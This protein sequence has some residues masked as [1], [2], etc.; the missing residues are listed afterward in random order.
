[1]PVRNHTKKRPRKFPWTFFAATRTFGGV[2]FFFLLSVVVVLSVPRHAQAARLW[3]S[4]FEMGTSTQG[5][6]GEFGSPAKATSTVV[7]SGSYAARLNGFSSFTSIGITVS[8]TNLNGPYFVR[9]YLY[10]TTLP[11]ASNTIMALRSS[12]G[13]RIVFIK[14]DSTGKLILADEDGQIGSSTALS[15][16]SW[17]RVEVQYDRTGAGGF[18]V[19]RA[20]LDG[21]EFAGA[22]NRN[23]S[24]GINRFSLGANISTE[25]Q[26]VGDW[27][28]DDVAMNDNAGS[29]QN[30]FPGEGKIVHLRPN[31]AGDNA[32]GTRGGANTGSDWGQLSEVTP[33]SA[34]TYYILDV[35][36][37]IIDVNIDAA[38]VAGMS[39]TDIISLVQVGIRERAATAAAEGWKVRIKSQGGGTV[40]SSATTTHD[41]IT[42]KTNGDIVSHIYPLTAYVD[43]QAGGAWTTALLDNSQ[44]GVLAGDATPD[45]WVSTLWALVEYTTPPRLEQIHYR[46]RNDD[47][48]EGAGGG[49]WHDFSW[50]YRQKITVQSSK[51]SSP[52]SNFPVYLDLAD[53]GNDFWAHVGSTCGDIRMT[54]A[55]GI[56]EIP[57]ELVSCSSTAKTG[58]VHFKAPSLASA[59]NTDFYAYF[60]NSGASDYAS[61][62]TYGANNVWDS[63]YKGVWHFEESLIDEGSTTDVHA[64]STSNPNDGDQVGE[65]DGVGKIGRGIKFDGTNDTVNANSDASL[66]N[67]AVKTASFWVKR[68]D[69]TRSQ[70]IV[71]KGAYNASGNGWIAEIR[72]NSGS[73]ADTI[74]YAH[75]WSGSAGGGATWYG[76][77]ALS[78][79]NAWYYATIVY[80]SGSASNNPLIYVN[81]SA[82][83][84]GEL[85]APSGT[86]GDDNASNLEFGINQSTYSNSEVDEVRI[87][88]IA[89]SASW[90]MTDYNNQSSPST[91][92]TTSTVEASSSGTT[93]AAAEDQPIFDVPKQTTRRL[94]FEISNEGVGVSVATQYRIEYATSSGASTWTQIGTGAASTN[95]WVMTPSQLVEGANTTDVAGGLN[96]ENTTFVAGRQLETSN[97]S[98]AITL[99]STEFTELEYSIAATSTA[100][101]GQTYYFRL[102]N[103]GA[104]LDAYTIYASATLAAAASPNLTQIHYRWS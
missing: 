64:D 82:E 71:Q 18:H 8:S 78:D 10:V 3:S 104:P 91:F 37:D 14:L 97:Q 72:S 38:S 70:G 6:E 17:Y 62:A 39:A 16:N 74:L 81:G 84:V 49:S 73:G 52:Q 86:E 43:P 7:H 61:S 68:V 2:F 1:M 44:I 28:F 34:G 57:R 59:T 50:N 47:G 55:D 92:Y 31:G 95:H 33:D 79:L 46:W 21:V 22:V 94:R 93:W 100:I 23:L 30:T 36:N 42:W 98:A 54:S 48:G 67:I 35:D 58:E 25:A 96:N 19:A 88:N 20:R 40:L 27:Y 4:G 13:V 87:S 99:A 69:N 51:V 77:T 53:M 80:D 26:T 45:V 60:G 85:T 24:S 63:N 12:G 75:R 56:T 65:D 103:A 32:M 76:S 11:T 41:D 101:A 29:Y 5:V 15:L 66:D 102:T 89:R 90:V 83:T 9:T